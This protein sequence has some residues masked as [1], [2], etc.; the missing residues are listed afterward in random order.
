ME[1]TDRSV[2]SVYKEINKPNLA[3]QRLYKTLIKLLHN[4]FS[5]SH[6]SIEYWHPR[7][8]GVPRSITEMPR[9]PEVC[10][11]SYVAQKSI[12]Q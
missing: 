2:L 7:K 3:R 10:A 12:I 8:H 6:Q 9:G 5:E 1:G 11:P 4:H